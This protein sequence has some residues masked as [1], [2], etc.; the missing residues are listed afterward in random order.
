[1]T[2]TRG[3]RAKTSVIRLLTTLLDHEKH[4]ARE[5]AVLYAERW[6][7]EIAF[8]HLKK[9]LRGAR[10]VL[11]GKSEALAR[12]EAWAFLLVHNMIAAVA[13]RAAALAGIDPDLIPFTAVLGLVRAGLTQTSR[14]VRSPPSRPPRSRAHPIA[15][16]WHALQAELD[17]LHY[18]SPSS[19]HYPYQR[20]FGGLER[21]SSSRRGSASWRV[22]T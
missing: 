11:R 14:N 20:R 3:G 18:R 16:L 10:R 8:L 22:A 4:P 21:F 7:I 6:Q 2:R 17:D 5:I 9:T 12:Q 1:M 15:G 13:A 19:K